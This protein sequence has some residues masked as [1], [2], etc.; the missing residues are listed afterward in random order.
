MLCWYYYQTLF[1]GR[2]DTLFVQIFKNAFKTDNFL[3]CKELSRSNY[4]TRFADLVTILH[5]E[6]CIVKGYTNLLVTSFF[7]ID[8]SKSV[9]LL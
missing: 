7:D 2:K 1:S 4:P 6:K 5:G 3:D 9:K 8:F